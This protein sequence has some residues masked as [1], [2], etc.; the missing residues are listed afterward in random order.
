MSICRVI[1]IIEINS[2]RTCSNFKL[3]VRFLKL[4]KWLIQVLSKNQF[5]LPI[6]KA[7]GL[8]KAS[9]ST[10]GGLLSLVL[11]NN[12]KSSSPEDTLDLKSCY[13]INNH[14]LKFWNKNQNKPNRKDTLRAAQRLFITVQPYLIQVSQR[15]RWRG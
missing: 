4:F 1:S 11:Q 15:C 14:K 10:I 13:G 2:V 6:D 9:N 12:S 5:P 3:F 8:L 7:V